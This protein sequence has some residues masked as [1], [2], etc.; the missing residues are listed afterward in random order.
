[1]LLQYRTQF[2]QFRSGQELELAGEAGES[3]G[4]LDTSGDG[5]EVEGK[6]PDGNFAKP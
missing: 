1:M 6:A 4:L 3:D 5:G 2:Q